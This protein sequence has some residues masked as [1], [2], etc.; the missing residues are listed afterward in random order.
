M[1]IVRVTYLVFLRSSSPRNDATSRTHAMKFL[2]AF[3]AGWIAF[4]LAD[5]A[6]YDGQ[7]V[8]LVATFAG[9]IASGFAPR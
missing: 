9:S 4:Y 7:H 3:A 5:Q 2:L 8:Q 1:K 6:L